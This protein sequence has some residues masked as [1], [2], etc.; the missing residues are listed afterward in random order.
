MGLL[1]DVQRQTVSNLELR[2]AITLTPDQ[3]VRHA[4]D[5]MRS[6]ELGCVIVVDDR[7]QLVGVFTERRLL[8]MLAT[9][10]GGLD[11]PVGKHVASAWNTVRLADPI[12]R[13]IDVM[14]SR[15]LRFVVVVDDEGHPVG[16]TGQKGV[17]EYIAE[18]FPRQVKSQLLETKLFMEKREG[19]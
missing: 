2:E 4:V 5:L 8:R 1:E 13:V 12:A 11:D 17:M 6:R 15:N 3:S 14:E 10:S 18:H 19:G 7:N 9:T 16:L